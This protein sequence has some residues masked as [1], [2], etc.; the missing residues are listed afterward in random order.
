MK[1]VRRPD[2]SIGVSGASS[3]RENNNKQTHRAYCYKQRVCKGLNRRWLEMSS[4]K[5]GAIVMAR[6]LVH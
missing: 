1:C 2:S 4:G 5:A 6:A 3:E